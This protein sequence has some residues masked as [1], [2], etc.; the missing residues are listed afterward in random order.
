LPCATNV[1]VATAAQF[2]GELYQVMAEGYSLGGPSPGR[3]AFERHAD[4]P[5]SSADP[6]SGLAGAYGP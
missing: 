6:A 5:S 3:A 4:V 1:Y 2:V